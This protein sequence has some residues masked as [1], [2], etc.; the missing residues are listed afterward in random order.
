MHTYEEQAIK[1]EVVTS[2]NKFVLLLPKI[3]WTEPSVLG[4]FFGERCRTNLVRAGRLVERRRRS[5]PA[6]LVDPPSH[7]IPPRS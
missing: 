5:R 4:T 6:L 2:T 3:M 7:E 1:K